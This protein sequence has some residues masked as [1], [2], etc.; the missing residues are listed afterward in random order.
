MGQRFLRRLVS[1]VEPPS[2]DRAEGFTSA[3]FSLPSLIFSADMIRRFLLLLA[4]SLPFLAAAQTSSNLS[5]LGRWDK[6]SLPFTFGLAYN[7]VYGWANPADSREYAILGTMEY[8]YFI[9]VTIPTAP[10]VRDSV[11]GKDI[12]CI[13]RDFKT[14]NGYAYGVADENASSLQIFDLT[15]LPD[16]V[17]KVLDSDAYFQRAHNVFIDTA[18]GLMYVCGSNTMNPG[19]IVFDLTVNP[20]NPPVV[21]NGPTGGYVHDLYVRNDTAY[22][23]QGY[24]GLGVWDFTTPSAPV[25]I[26]GLP[27]YP[28]AGYNHSGWMMPGT[29]IYV[30][31]DETWGK[32]IKVL[33]VTDPSSI[34]VL[35]L[36]K[37]MMLAPADTNSIPHNP[38][39]AGTYACISYYHEGVVIFDIRNPSAP[40]RNA[41]YDTWPNVDYAGYAG[42]WGVYP[43]L[44]SGNILGSD[45][46]NG[47]YI[48]RPN[49]PF[50][51]DMSNS[52]A[53]TD[54][55]C[56]GASDGTITLTPGG[57][58]GP[59]SYVWSTGDTTVSVSG[60][61][62]GTY[63]V[64]ISDRYGFTY[65]DSA[66][67]TGPAPITASAVV[68]DEGC[69]SA[70]DGTITL[71]PSGGT[72]PYS[73]S[74][75]SGATGSPLT[76]LTA[77]TYIGTVTDSLGCTWTDTFTVGS[78]T[79]MP[80]VDAGAD[81]TFCKTLSSMSAANPSPGT[82]MWS[83]ASGGAFFSPPGSPTATAFAMTAGTN[84]W[85]WTVTQGACVWHD[86]ITVYVSA[87]AAADAGPN[88]TV[89]GSS[90]LL[91]GSD[92]T[93]GTGSWA[94]GPGS[95]GSFSSVSDPNA[96]VSAMP[97]G[98][99]TL[100]WI[101]T[102]GTCTDS[103]EVILN[104]VYDPVSGFTYSPAFP[105][106]DFT[107]TSTYATGYSWDFGDGGTSLL[108]NPSHSYST[109]GSYWVCLITTNACGSDTLCDSIS[110]DPLGIMDGRNGGFVVYPNPSAGTFSLMSS[111]YIS[112]AVKWEVWSLNGQV[113]ASGLWSSP[114]DL[115][116]VQTLSAGM[117]ILRL[118]TDD[119]QVNIPVGIT[120]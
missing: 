74:W 59:Y 108:A 63:Y 43:F 46:V 56:G 21:Y 16:S 68:T 69:G 102:E 27:T 98:T 80:M 29:N 48:L 11:R 41:W 53:V 25:Q 114:T 73:Y 85:V 71:T 15:Y 49:F 118:Q 86:T 8:T 19:L 3:I 36:M 58:T 120:K 75:S 23:N 51:L 17:H 34:A 57:G 40:V 103:S 93:P 82:G 47:L 65:L 5:L 44:P 13:H 22:L 119:K 109:P 83:V 106:V 10:V 12:G 90:W 67:I 91:S 101:V 60:L 32:A 111:G 84:T 113:M 54:E 64:T 31:C 42:V 88:A 52:S 39:V 107:S 28:A 76:G 37:S 81:T 115:I 89:C 112:Q 116:D 117:Y 9:E 72:A 105:T 35:A 50:P 97:P 24:S 38:L 61:S 79:A 92:P 14:Y 110:T 18:S 20:E 78:V 2:K 1:Y 33:D 95:S 7:E 87:S 70:A 4:V 62:P 100:Y 26:G 96:T 30:M 94:F 45:V 104:V 6:D 55:T 99:Q 77:G 66:T